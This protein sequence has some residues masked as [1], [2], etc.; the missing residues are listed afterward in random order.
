MRK[1]ASSVLGLT[2]TIGLTFFGFGYYSQGLTAP[3]LNQG[4]LAPCP[5]RPC[6]VNSESGATDK[7]AIGPIPIT[8]QMAGEPLVLVQEAVTQLGGKVVLADNNYLAATFTSAIFGFVDDVEF[9][10]DPDEKVVHV[11][12]ASR[13]GYYDFE[14][15]RKRV[16]KIRG[17]VTALSK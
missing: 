12:S 5:S 10:V 13:T 6:C 8:A 7:H 1:L 2:A 15:N 17:I 4:K 11:R 3:G 14:V 16:E 9:R